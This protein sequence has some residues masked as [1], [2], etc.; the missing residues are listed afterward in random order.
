VSTADERIRRLFEERP[1][2][3]GLAESVC[4]AVSADPALLRA[5]RLRFLPDTDA[6][7]EAD[8]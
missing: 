5:A 2:V 1:E 4:L 3:V 6:G 8:L 7:V